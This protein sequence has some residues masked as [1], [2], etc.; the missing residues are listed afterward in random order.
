MP[1][2]GYLG[3]RELGVLINLLKED[4]I[5]KHFNFERNFGTYPKYI[6]NISEENIS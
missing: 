1:N 4:L 2:W 5:D 3:Q 6:L